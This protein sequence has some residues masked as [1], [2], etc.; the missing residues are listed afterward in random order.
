MFQFDETDSL[1]LFP[2]M[3]T[4]VTLYH[5]VFMTWMSLHRP[6]SPMRT[7]CVRVVDISIID[8]H[9]LNFMF[10]ILVQDILVYPYF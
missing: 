5:G 4:N 6:I 2:R 3:E 10:I 8:Y 9:Y 1:N 7:Y